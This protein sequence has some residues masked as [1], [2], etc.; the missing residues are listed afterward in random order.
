MDSNSQ[1][2]KQS[3]TRKVFRLVSLEP[4][5]LY[6]WV[7]RTSVLNNKT[8]CMILYN[9]ASLECMVRYFQD[10]MEAHMFLTDVVYGG[11]DVPKTG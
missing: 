9:V 8:I 5:E 3:G 2:R 6:D 10:E 1:S 11:D 4:I 7:I